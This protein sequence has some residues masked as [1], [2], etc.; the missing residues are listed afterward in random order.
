MVLAMTMLMLML[1]M[2]DNEMIA[3][4]P[5]A[6]NEGNAMW[7]EGHDGD[8]P[9]FENQKSRGPEICGCFVKFWLNCFIQKNINVIEMSNGK[10]YNKFQLDRNVYFHFDK[11]KKL[12]LKLFKIIKEMKGEKENMKKCMKTKKNC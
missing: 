2:I 7:V 5:S 9:L 6:D 10:K 4:P 8:R 3:G 1:M 12:F 11:D